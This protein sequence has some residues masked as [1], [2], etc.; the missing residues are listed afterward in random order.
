MEETVRNEERDIAAGSRSA[1]GTEEPP[2]KSTFKDYFVIFVRRKC[3]DL[4]LY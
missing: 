4:G 1:E 3:C 2:A